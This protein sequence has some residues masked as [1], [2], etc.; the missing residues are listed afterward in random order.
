MSRFYNLTYN[1][2]INIMIKLQGAH[3]IVWGIGLPLVKPS[4][5]K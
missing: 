1:V 4:R 2:Q 3:F 5:L